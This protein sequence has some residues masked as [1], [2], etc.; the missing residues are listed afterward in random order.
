MK[1]NKKN[2]EAAESIYAQLS[3]EDIFF[4]ESVTLSLFE[5]MLDHK[6]AIIIFPQD[7]DEVKI[8]TY[9]VDKDG[10]YEVLSRVIESMRKDVGSMP[11]SDML[12]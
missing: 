9:N 4:A 6:R 3:K 1:T 2:K 8:S 5:A 7:N 12:Q 11:S 10:L